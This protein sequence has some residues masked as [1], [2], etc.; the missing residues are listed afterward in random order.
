MKKIIGVLGISLIALIGYVFVNGGVTAIGEV[1]R[2]DVPES[3]VEIYTDVERLEEASDLVVLARPVGEPYNHV[4][5]D[6]KFPHYYW[7]ETMFEVE[8]VYHGEVPNE[9][10]QQ[11]KVIEPYAYVRSNN[12][13]ASQY[14]EV[15][16]EDSSYLLFLRKKD[17]D[18]IA[19]L[20]IATY[21]GKFEVSS[22]ADGGF[23][24]TGNAEL[25]EL[26]R[27]VE[28]KYGSIK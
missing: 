4:E 28:G 23:E 26:K 18:E 5:M 14:Y 10:P 8:H 25:D 6:G 17:S 21:H 22:D 1:K 11:L 3:F 24:S 15:T 12:L 20:P 7:T 9:V 2:T 27:S 16:K 19:Y 13:I